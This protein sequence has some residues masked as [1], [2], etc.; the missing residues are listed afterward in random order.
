MAWSNFHATAIHKPLGQDFHHAIRIVMMAKAND[1]V[2][3]IAD[4]TSRTL[5]TWSHRLLKPEIQHV[6]QE[7][8]GK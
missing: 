4:E 1:E 7:H 6:V 2:I 3:C 5:Q 8:V